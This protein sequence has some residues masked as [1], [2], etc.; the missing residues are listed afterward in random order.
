M[1]LGDVEKYTPAAWSRKNI[2]GLNGKIFRTRKQGEAVPSAARVPDSTARSVVHAVSLKAMKE[3]T[4]TVA[5]NKFHL[6]S[7]SLVFSL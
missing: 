6:P 5:N 3:T 2:R 7:H 4:Q 1:L